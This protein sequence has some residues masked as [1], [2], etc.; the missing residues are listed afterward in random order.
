MGFLKTAS[1]ADVNKA[2]SLLSRI[3]DENPAHWPYGL[4][5]SH[6][7]PGDL[8]LVYK[9]AS[10]DPVGFVGW[11]E[12]AVGFEKLGFYSVGTLP[13]HR[14][15]GAARTGLSQLLAVKSAGVDRVMA[16]VVDGNTPS[17]KLANRLGVPVIKV[18]G[19][20]TLAKSVLKSP[21]TYSVPAGAYGTAAFQDSA[22][23][24]DE[25]FSPGKIFD[26]GGN[27]KSRN[28]I[29]LINAILG[30][31]GGAGMTTGVSKWREA[32]RLNGF[33]LAT[34][35]ARKELKGDAMKF[36]A[37][38]GASMTIAPI[39]KDLQMHGHK[40][41]EAIDRTSKQVPDLIAA[42]RDKTQQATG[43]IMG[44]DSNKTLWAAGIL[45]TAIGVGA[46]GLSKSLK[47]PEPG[48]RLKVTLPTKNPNDGETQLDLPYD[49]T[50]PLSP[51]LRARLDLGANR[52]LQA[53]S[54]SWI[55]R[56]GQK[57]PDMAVS[58]SDS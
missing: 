44:G 41:I 50:R 54:K 16:L 38:G 13:E 24:P 31:V 3:Y 12:R 56:R 6:F 30:G 27:D 20:G 34:Q 37:G 8:F 29:N 15:L 28:Q 43:G 9:Q 33:D 26:V 32:G 49:P 2:A 51:A 47:R 46:Y 14:G 17:E 48:A 42:I 7:D 19:L 35:A 5:V 55:H 25:P 58:D 36:L 1:A 39:T 40:A 22:M 21:Y 23:H 57:A 10:E 4:T 18:A 45:S 11:Q 52:R 53:E